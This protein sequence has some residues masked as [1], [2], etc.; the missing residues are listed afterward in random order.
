MADAVQSFREAMAAA[1]L[2]FDGEIITDGRVHRFKSRGDKRADSWLV[3]HADG[4]AAGAFGCWRTGQRHAWREERASFATIADRQRFQRETA[5][6]QKRRDTAIREAQAAAAER[7]R[8][9]WKRLGPANQNHPYLKTKGIAAHSARQFGSTLALPIHEIAGGKLL[10][11]QFISLVGDKRFLSRGRVKGC[12]IMLAEACENLS[13]ILIAEG[14]ATAATLREAVHVPVAAA[15]FAANL[16]AVARAVRKKYPKARIIIC[17]DNDTETTGNPGLRYATEAAN[18]TRSVLAIPRSK[19]APCKTLDW[20]D[21]ARAEGLAAVRAQI[22]AAMNPKIAAFG[23][24]ASEV[25]ETPVAWLWKGRIARGKLTIIDGNPGDGKSTFT[26]SVAGNVSTGRNFPD[27][28]PCQRGRVILVSAEDDGAD[29]VAP[30]LRAAEADLSAIRIMPAASERDGKVHVLTF[31]DDLPFFEEAIKT[32]KADLVVVDPLTAFLSDRVD[33]HRDGSIRRVLAELALIAQRTGAAIV[34]VRHLNKMTSE[35][36]AMFRGGGSIA[37]VAAARAAFL[38]GLDP[39]DAGPVSE[40]RRVFACVKSNLAPMPP[41][42]L[43]R[44]VQNSGDSVAALEWVA[45]TSAL[46]ADDLLA[47]HDPRKTDALEE[48]IA[49][50]RVELDEGAKPVL[51]VE[52]HAKQAGIKFATL[53]R[54]RRHLGIRARRKGFSGQ[55][56][57]SLPDDDQKPDGPIEPESAVPEAA[58]PSNGKSKSADSNSDLTFEQARA[59]ARKCEAQGKDVADAIENGELF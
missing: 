16:L 44:L 24:L 18:E 54:A 7:A 43:F 52:Q 22:E 9:F 3:L 13:T 20:N 46:T 38:I 51:D 5:E 27:G 47:S 32:E 19:D 58:A 26:I 34:L 11:L 33:S 45:G 35:S 49:F 59:I 39:N 2:A 12:A 23:Q 21:V 6:A 17:G 28:A 40:R 42:L 53:K 50:L 57:V 25:R 15:L 31:P 1:G 37:I 29:T 14:F 41:S 36:K 55:W 4:V 56:L 48:A 10:N 8:K 30:R